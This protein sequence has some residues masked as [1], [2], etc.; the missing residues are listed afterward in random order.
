MRGVF[1]FLSTCIALSTIIRGTASQ[2][3]TP[4]PTDGECIEFGDVSDLQL[5]P[6]CSLKQIIKQAMSVIRPFFKDFP[7]DNKAMCYD[8]T[9]GL[10]YDVADAAFIPCL[11][12]SC[13]NILSTVMSAFYQPG[14]GLEDLQKMNKS[15]LTAHF[16]YAMELATADIK[17]ET[18]KMVCPEAGERPPFMVLL[19]ES[20]NTTEISLEV[21]NNIEVV[22]SMLFND[23]DFTSKS[24]DTD[25][26]QFFRNN[27]EGAFSSVDPVQMINL[28]APNRPD[29]AIIT[30]LLAGSH[31]KTAQKLITTELEQLFCS[32][33]DEAGGESADRVSGASMTNVSTSLLLGSSLIVYIMAKFI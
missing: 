22:L 11:Y 19:P 32:N 23:P 28:F 24:T 25:D 21:L 26:C 12:G 16:K 33:G 17:N 8:K 27:I 3:T 1:L 13:S 9:S 4:P 30:T 2:T 14:E 29:M 15:E 6:S 20:F 18:L 5:M 7:F 31:V 10:I